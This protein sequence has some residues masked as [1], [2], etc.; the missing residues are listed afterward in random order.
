MKT[1]LLIEAD[2]AVLRLE[3]QILRESG[4]AA[5][6]VADGEQARKKLDATPYHGV[7]LDLGVPGADGYALAKELGAAN[8]NTPLVIVGADAPDARKRA[9]EAGAL[10][11]LSKPF[12]AEAF[13]SALHSTISPEG[14]RGVGPPTGRGR[15]AIPVSVAPPPGR[16]A[17]SEPPA[18]PS[19]SRS[20][21]SEGAI[22]VRF[23]G[24]PLYWSEPDADGGWR[25]GRCE[26]GLLAAAVVG[27]SC[28]VCHAEVAGVPERRGLPLGWLILILTVALLAGWLLL[29]WE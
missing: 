19:E 23:Q 18:E 3:Q 12:G 17:P 2:P 7:V 29:R 9:F 20:T 27:Q 11:F 14:S 1:I 6:W 4:Y 10:A 26:V 24:G 5:E 25:C 8:R 15:P 22:A 13:R 21:R 28:S 16:P